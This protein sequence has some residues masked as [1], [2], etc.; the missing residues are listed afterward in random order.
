MAFTPPTYNLTVNIWHYATWFGN[1][2]T[3]IPVADLTSLANLAV[4]R[5]TTAHD[6]DY[7][8]LLLPP[9]TDIRDELHESNNSSHG[10]IVE[11]PA[12]SG[13]YYGVIATDDAGKGFSNE[14]RVA[15]IGYVS[16]FRAVLPAWPVPY[17]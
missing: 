1:F 2:P 14:H 13:R 8:W 16:P 9:L 10:D 6:I 4:G 15:A 5:R 11:V 7:M 12:G 3:T 17:P